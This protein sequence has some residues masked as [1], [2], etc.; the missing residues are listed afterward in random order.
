LKAILSILMSIL[1]AVSAV[2]GCCRSYALASSP[3]SSVSPQIAQQAPCGCKN[4]GCNRQHKSQPST[5]S[6]TPEC[7]GICTYVPSQKTQVDSTQLVVRFDLAAL[8]PT[9]E[10]DHIAKVGDWGLR[11]SRADSEPPL[12]LHLLHQ[13][14]VI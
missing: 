4:P 11:G 3:A 12:R 14:L 2:F 9:L 13:I 10:S 8:S 1:L 5:P 7:R 6:K